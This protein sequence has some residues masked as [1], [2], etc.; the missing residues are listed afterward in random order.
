MSILGF[1]FFS[2]G[3]YGFFGCLR[4]FPGPSF[5]EIFQ[6]FYFYRFFTFSLRFFQTVYAL[7]DCCRITVLPLFL[8]GRHFA[9]VSAGRRFCFGLGRE[10]PCCLFSWIRQF[11]HTVESILFSMQC[12]FDLFSKC[13][14]VQRPLLMVL[15]LLALSKTAGT[16]CSYD[17]EEKRLF[18]R[19]S[20][21]I[22]EVAAYP[23][24]INVVLFFDESLFCVYGPPSDLRFNVS[25]LF[26]KPLKV[27]TLVSANENCK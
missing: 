2:T 18:C 21:E 16:I 10:S 6:V 22:R 12:V 14:L 13:F 17:P 27:L 15:I 9:L 26:H 25:A 5:C 8:T 7:S 20:F 3:F 19:E 4:H 24:A 23:F 1:R 11:L